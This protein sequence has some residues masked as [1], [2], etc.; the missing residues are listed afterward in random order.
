SKIHVD[1]E[2]VHSLKICQ[3]THGAANIGSDDLRQIRGETFSTPYVIDQI[4]PHIGRI[5]C[6]CNMDIAG[7]VILPES[8]VD[9]C[10]VISIPGY[11]IS[12][13]SDIE[14]IIRVASYHNITYDW[15]SDRASTGNYTIGPRWE[16]NTVI[17]VR[18]RNC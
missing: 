7:N 18:I 4:I 6:C 1:L 14:N 16:R 3:S 8:R 17:T 12:R 13:S 11:I 9:L 2:L 5:G 10:I 15:S